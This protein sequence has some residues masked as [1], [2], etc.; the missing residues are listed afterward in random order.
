MI[1][2]WIGNSRR[3]SGPIADSIR[4][5]FHPAP[6][7]RSRD[8]AI[9]P[10]SRSG[11]RPES[12]PS[13]GSYFLFS[14]PK[15]LSEKEAKRTQQILQANCAFILNFNILAMQKSPFS[16]LFVV[17]NGETMGFVARS[18]ESF[19]IRE[20]RD[21]SDDVVPLPLRPLG[22]PDDWYFNAQFG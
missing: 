5:S 2:R 12:P 3:K 20:G 13:P 15:K 19:Q 18:Y 22:E 9:R 16:N 1:C 10:G 7:P 8:F 14:P 17:S 21:F 11:R 4:H 6:R